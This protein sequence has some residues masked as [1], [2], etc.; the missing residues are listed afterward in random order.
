MSWSLHRRRVAAILASSAVVLGLTDIGASAQP[1]GSGLYLTTYVNESGYW[2]ANGALHRIDLNNTTT[3]VGSAVQWA[4]E[5][6]L[7]P[8]AMTV[9]LVDGDNYDA[10][11]IDYDYGDNLL[12]AWVSCPDTATT[13]GTHPNKVC[14][15]QKIHWNLYS[16]YASRQDTVHERRAIAC[17][18]LGHTVGLDHADS[19]PES[20]MLVAAPQDRPTRYSPHDKQHI[21]GYYG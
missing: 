4:M 3:N 19:N 16:G 21:N 7:E 20:C 12:N 15:G 17:Q 5:N 1:F 13:S 18:E 2:L 8:T 11:V 9:E 14:H 6:A 10:R